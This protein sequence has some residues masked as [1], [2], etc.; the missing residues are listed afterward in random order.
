MP[1]FVGFVT[2]IRE[3]RRSEEA[4]RRSEK[5]YRTLISNLPG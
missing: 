3:R 2:D 5:Q 1:L 4:V